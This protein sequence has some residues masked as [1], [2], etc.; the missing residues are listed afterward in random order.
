MTTKIVIVGGGLSGLSAALFL[1]NAGLGD[2]II[3]LEKEMECGGL[4][5]S[6]DYGHGI[7]FFDKGIHHFSET[8]VKEI[9]RQFSEIFNFSDWRELSGTERTLSGNYFHGT[10]NIKTQ[11]CC[12]RDLQDNEE[13]LLDFLEN[14][15][16]K[17]EHNVCAESLQQE[18]EYRFGS[19]IANSI[20][21]PI[22]ERKF[23]A[24]IN[25]LDNMSISLCPFDRI[26]LYDEEKCIEQ[27]DSKYSSLIAFQDQ[28]NL[29]HQKHSPLKSYYPTKYGLSHVIQDLTRKLQ[30]MGVEIRTC[31]WIKHFVI[32]KNHIDKVVLN[33][34]ARIDI[35]GLMWSIGLPSLCK[36]LQIP[37]S[38]IPFDKPLKTVLVNLLVTEV[39]EMDDLHSFF[40]YDDLGLNIYRVTNYTNYCEDARRNGLYPLSV[41]IFFDEFGSHDKHFIGEQTIEALIKIGVVSHKRQV[42]FVETEFLAT[43]F[44]MPTVKNVSGMN[45]IRSRVEHRRIENLSLN[46]ILSQEK[47]FYMTDIIKRT[48]E[49]CKN[50]EFICQSETCVEN[51]RS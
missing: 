25:E 4:L 11:Y 39:S 46:G 32:D 6:F 10:L 22:L 37:V 42:R 5:S 26:G 49:L 3:V 27:L 19:K 2:K 13:L 41:E 17:N 40:C 31:E 7:G 21:K 24:S 14:F 29:P 18:L 50:S 20:V 33:N 48:Y 28:R 15:E 47:L 45:E 36:L 9:D 30:N 35:E 16:N 38:D 1:A 23:Y 44:P 12:I 43:G 34:G 51:K 8:G